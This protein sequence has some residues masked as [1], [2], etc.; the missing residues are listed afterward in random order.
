MEKIA[1]KLYKPNDENFTDF[2]LFVNGPRELLP[3]EHYLVWFRI[4]RD[5]MI[6]IVKHSSQENIK[7]KANKYYQQCEKLRLS[8]YNGENLQILN[9]SAIKLVNEVHNFKKEILILQLN[10]KLNILLPPTFIS[11]MLNELDKFRFMVHSM[12]ITGE[13]PHNTA[14]NEHKLWGADIEGHLDTIKNSTDT[15]NNNIR[16]TVYKQKKTFCLINKTTNEIISYLN[17]G[18]IPNFPYIDA[19]TELITSET[20]LYLNLVSEIQELVENNFALGT[21]DEGILTHMLFEEMYYL[22]CITTA[23]PGYDPLKE[24]QQRI[25]S[26][27]LNVVNSIVG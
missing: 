7:Y 18:I 16:K 10:G 17:H 19:H 3:Q 14:I 5:H 13:F 4:I 6:F 2:Y 1:K 26:N 11:H 15:L 12:E 8:C 24:H 9:D 22:C 25:S 27:S 23:D 20:I 21:L